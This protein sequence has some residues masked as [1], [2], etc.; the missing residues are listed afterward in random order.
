MATTP[1]QDQEDIWDPYLRKAEAAARRKKE[2]L[3]K[4]HHCVLNTAGDVRDTSMV[5]LILECDLVLADGQY[6]AI[7]GLDPHTSSHLALYKLLVKEIRYVASYLKRRVMAHSMLQMPLTDIR[8]LCYRIAE[9]FDSLFYV[10]VK[11]GDED[12]KESN[13]AISFRWLDRYNCM[14]PIVSM[15]NREYQ[16]AAI[17]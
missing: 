7:L 2:L 16:K 12:G 8:S 10:P 1:D 13:F 17:S 9:N 14:W 3:N 6:M 11:P 5:Y 15:L 4:F